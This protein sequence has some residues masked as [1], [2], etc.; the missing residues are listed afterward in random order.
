M[1]WG[2]RMGQAR[3]RGTYEQRK[4]AAIKRRYEELEVEN[5]QQEKRKQRAAKRYN[6]LT[7]EQRESERLR[8]EILKG[9]YSIPLGV[10][11]DFKIRL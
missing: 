9:Y 8:A 10:L 3:N 2:V 7:P 5:I 1:L 11:G 4:A 6:S